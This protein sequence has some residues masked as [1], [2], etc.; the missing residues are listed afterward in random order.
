MA[1]NNNNT[2][3]YPGLEV[4]EYKA[5]SSNEAVNLILNG[6]EQEREM[7]ISRLRY[8]ENTLL[9]HGRISQKHVKVRAR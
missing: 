4:V 5:Q 2:A 1:A 8:V 6:M 9:E 7:L 3:T